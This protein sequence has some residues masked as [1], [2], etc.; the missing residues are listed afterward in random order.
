MVYNFALPPL[1]LHAAVSG[2]AGPLRRWARN[3]PKPE[4]SRLFLNFLASH[5]GVGLTP[6][7]GLVDDEAFAATLKEAQNRGA[8]IS[9]KAT[10]EGPVPYELNCSY[11]DTTAPASL[12]GPELRARAFLSTQAVL[13]ALSGLPAVYFH[14]WIGSPAWTEGPE[15]LGY[16]R[17]I[18]R[19]KPRIDLV[20][21]ELDD[22]ASF[23]SRVN[24]GFKKLLEFRQAEE[25]FNPDSPQ[26]VLDAGGAVFALLRGPD[27][28][29]RRVLCLQ[30]L[31]GSAGT[32]DISAVGE[33]GLSGDLAPWETRWVAFG[34]GRPLRELVL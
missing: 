10:P 26:E 17:A 25:A 24:T 33:A 1:V 7:K 12:G 19:E 20:E 14:S 27:D 16:N 9:Y 34:G 11:A 31:G 32:A 13:L 22:P 21:K 15:L 8:R 30:N 23:R 2:D 4:R 5:D 3:L 28:Q 29:G 6:A 18:N